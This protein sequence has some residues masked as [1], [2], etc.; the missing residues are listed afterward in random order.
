MAVNPLPPKGRGRAA[1]PFTSGQEKRASGGHLVSLM[2][3]TRVRGTW[4]TGV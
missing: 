2:C 4:E 3:D 1:S